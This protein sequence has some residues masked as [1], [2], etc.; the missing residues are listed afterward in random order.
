MIKG[1]C[2]FLTNE[3]ILIISLFCP[4][5]LENI[6]K[7]WKIYSHIPNSKKN[8]QYNWKIDSYN[9]KEICFNSLDIK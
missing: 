3:E 7:Y 2:W 8:C 5:G 4:H 9:S 6:S 1:I